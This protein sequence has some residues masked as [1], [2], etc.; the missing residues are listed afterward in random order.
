VTLASPG[1]RVGHPRREAAR[2]AGR[3]IGW[4]E[5]RT[6]ELHDRP[7]TLKLTRIPDRPY[8]T[9]SEVEIWGYPDAKR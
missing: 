9:L 1:A 8:L 5:S 7:L 3:L 4:S 2:G 6:T